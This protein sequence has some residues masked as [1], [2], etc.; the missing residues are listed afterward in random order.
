MLHKSP[1]GLFKNSRR[2]LASAIQSTAPSQ[3]IEGSR[4]KKFKSLLGGVSAAI[5]VAMANTDL[6]IRQGIKNKV[7]GDR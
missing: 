7:I 1:L 2:N 3:L 4:W 5:E 6:L